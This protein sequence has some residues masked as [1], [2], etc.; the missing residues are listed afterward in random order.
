MSN[1]DNCHTDHI[2]CRALR[3]K[4]QSLGMGQIGTVPILTIMY[5]F[6]SNDY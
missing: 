6:V 1:A 3:N 2:A 4:G 5:L